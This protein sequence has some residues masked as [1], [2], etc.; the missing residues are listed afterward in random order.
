MKLTEKQLRNIIKE[1]VQS[2]LR[3]YNDLSQSDWDYLIHNA[4][5]G[6]YSRESGEKVFKLKNEVKELNKE[7][8]KISQ[9]NLDRII[10]IVKSWG[11]GLK[12]ILRGEDC[13]RGEQYIRINDNARCYELICKNTGLSEDMVVNLLRKSGFDYVEIGE[14]S[15]P[16]FDRID[17]M[18][19][20]DKIDKEKQLY[21]NIS[22]K[23]GQLKGI[24]PL[25]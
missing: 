17:V 21:R 7:L 13:Q 1:S 19:S 20:D 16:E 8:S 6:A 9:E 10:K 24:R 3:E 14:F 23:E 2:V 18:F 22:W 4:Y 15:E 25:D 5:D 12:V 11:L